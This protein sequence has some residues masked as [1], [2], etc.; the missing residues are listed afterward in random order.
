MATLTYVSPDWGP[1]PDVAKTRAIAFYHLNELGWKGFDELDW[2]AFLLK[3][4]PSV[5]VILLACNIGKPTSFTALT[6]VADDMSEDDRHLLRD[7]II[8]KLAL[9]EISCHKTGPGSG[10]SDRRSALHR[11]AEISLTWQ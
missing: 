3:K 10:C 1:D 5:P 9:E 6:D 8:G 4:H 11:C 7:Y 2:T